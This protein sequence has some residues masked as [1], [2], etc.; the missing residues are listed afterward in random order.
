MACNPYGIL[1]PFFMKLLDKVAAE[2]GAI[3][4][5]DLN[6]NFRHDVVLEA[7]QRAIARCQTKG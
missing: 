4:I 2:Y 3:S 6:D 1:P 5:G 7:L